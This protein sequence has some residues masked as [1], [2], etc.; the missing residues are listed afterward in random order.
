MERLVS[1][2]ESLLA[3]GPAA[4]ADLRA[5]WASEAGRIAFRYLGAPPI[6]DDDLETLAESRLAAR[7]ADADAEYG[8]KLLSV[9]RVI[10]DPR[11][12]PWIAA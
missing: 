11:R 6:S 5:L 8:E 12:F 3:G 7:S 10:V 1:Q 4:E 9:L 2:L